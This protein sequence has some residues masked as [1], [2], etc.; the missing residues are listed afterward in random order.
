MPSTAK[1]TF[2]AN[3]AD[4]TELWNIH[5]EVAGQGAGR[6]YG[7][8]VLN[9]AAIV[10]ITAC[11]ESYIEDL[12]AESFD[13]LLANATSS[14]AIPPKV[15]AFASKAILEQKDSKKLWDIADSGWRVLLASHKESTLKRWLGDFNTPKTGQ[16][17][18]LY[19]ELLGIK[20]LSTSWY[21][22][23]IKSSSV[24]TKLDDFIQLRGDIAHRLKPANTVNKWKGTNYL[25]HV[26]SIVDRCELAV[27]AH[28]QTQTGILPW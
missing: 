26:S 28:L 11:W 2:L 16:V 8:E 24:E 22:A 4:I 13:F 7:V 27:A 25:A 21:W 23:G 9:R 15:R 1:I 12:A 3:K 20:R 10:F 6:K 14:A 18:D 17:N 19:I 5:Q